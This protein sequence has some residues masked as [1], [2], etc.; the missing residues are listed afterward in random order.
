MEESKRRTLDTGGSNNVYALMEDVLEKLKILDYETK[1][2]GP[3]RD[4][5]PLHR[6]FFAVPSTPSEQFP[7]F[8]GLAG[9]LLTVS[10]MDFVK[11]SEFD[12]E[13]PNSISDTVLRECQRLG[14]S[15]K[16]PATKLRHG[17]GDAVC[18]VLNFLADCALSKIDF[19]VKAPV[20]TM[21]DFVE[22]AEVDEE[23]E[24]GDDVTEET[25]E[26]DNVSPY[27]AYSH[28]QQQAPEKAEL[29]TGIQGV[30]ESNVDPAKWALEL[31]RVGPMLKWKNTGLS[32]NE[33]RTH[34]D[35]SVKHGSLVGD[36]FAV[37]RPILVIVGSKLQ[38]TVERIATKESSINKDFEHLGTDF[39]EKQKNL[40]S[41]Q[42]RYNELSQSVA[43]LTGDL[44][45]KT[46]MVEQVKAKMSERNDKITDTS[47]LN[48]ISSSL[49]SLRKE[50]SQME[51]RIGVVS[52]TLLQHRAM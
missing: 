18:S 17:S 51:L 34:L 43:E 9:W 27:A 41:I 5:K 40:D 36:R 32:S 4:F 49:A 12:D 37:V 44:S 14:F 3:R 11:W 21:A 13:D 2:L 48:R 30:V 35:Q 38:Q 25:H 7:Y 52:Q 42:E 31:E 24:I 45:R 22:E 1:F 23:A 8:A 33:W 15:P 6:C 28:T 50:T 10:G 19:S 39:R 47:P 46:D 16:F 20:Y 29:D 26:V